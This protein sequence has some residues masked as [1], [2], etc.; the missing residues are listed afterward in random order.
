M[1]KQNKTAY[2]R[3]AHDHIET[4]D[5][6]GKMKVY[7]F[8]RYPSVND[9]G[10]QTN[11]FRNNAEVNNPKQFGLKMFNTSVEAFAAYQRQKIAADAGL[12][13]PVGMMIRWIIRRGGQFK[14][15][16]INRWGYETAIADCSPLARRTAQI[17]SSPSIVSSFHAFLMENGISV[18]NSPFTS[19]NVNKFFAEW[20]YMWDG[21]C[22]NDPIPSNAIGT[23]VLCDP[24]SP[25]DYLRGE[26]NIRTKLRELDINGT[27]Y[28][29]ISEYD[30]GTAKWGDYL[31]LGMCYNEDH[32]AH[33]GNDLHAGNMGLWKNTPVV[34]DFGYHIA[35][36][37]FTRSYTG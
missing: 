14:D 22:E 8:T 6:M 37:Y 5:V 19:K 11:F 2:P 30:G 20:E 24:F 35:A 27:Q 18:S 32:N 25:F 3:F 26:R 23:L 28:D 29:D 7:E 15:R 12:A 36:P 17:L 31:R 21:F 34:I 10:C 33:M 4:H 9:A 13:P 16:K 1:K